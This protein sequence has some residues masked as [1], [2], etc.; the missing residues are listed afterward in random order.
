MIYFLLAEGFEE[1]EAIAPF[2]MVKRAGKEA[3]FVSVSNELTV[4][5]AH[6]V[7]IIADMLLKDISAEQGEMIV[8]PGG[9]LGVENLDKTEGFDE[10]LRSFAEKDRYICA[11]CAA[12]SFLGKRGYLDGR[13]AVCYPEQEFEQHLNKSNIQKSRVVRDGKFI[14]AIGAGASLDFG[15]ELVSV[16]KDKETAARI[17]SA[18]K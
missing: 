14:T 10:I 11:I 1:T 2:D 4:I 16:L 6:G 12:P 18:I 8:L 7:K 3:A 5:G 13:N 9:K 17:K 15:F